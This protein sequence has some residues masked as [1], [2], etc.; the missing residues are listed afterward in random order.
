MK[1]QLP[2][3][4]IRRFWTMLAFVLL[5]MAA[6]VITFDQG[7]SA[8]AQAQSNCGG[9]NQRPCSVFER[10]PS[11]NSGLIEDF[12]RNRC[13]R[14]TPVPTST[15][16][17]RP[18]C[19]ANG[20]R[21]CL[22]TE[23]V[24]SCNSGLVE[25]FSR[26]RC[27]RPTPVPTSTPTP[28]PVCGAN[29]QR[30]CLITERVP[31]C[32]SGLVEDFSRN[33]CVR[34]AP[35]PVLDC[36]AEGQRP[37]LLTERMNS[38]D[39]GLFEDFAYGKCVAEPT[40]GP[41]VQADVDAFMSENRAILEAVDDF[42]ETIT[43]EKN[44]AFFSSGEF[45]RLIEA[46]RFAEIQKRLGTNAFIE[47][48][49][50][51]QIAQGR[52]PAQNQLVGFR[53]SR[54]NSGALPFIRTV[55]IGFTIDAAV[56]AGADYEMGIA[57]DTVNG[58]PDGYDSYSSKYGFSAGASASLQLGL[59]F[60]P[61]E[62]LS[63]GSNGFTVAGGYKVGAALALWFPSGHEKDLYSTV[64]PENDLGFAWSYGFSIEVGVGVEFDVSYLWTYTLMDSAKGQ[65][66]EFGKRA[67]SVFEISGLDWSPCEESL[68][69]K[70][71]KCFPEETVPSDVA[72]PTPNP[73]LA[74]LAGESYKT[75]PDF[76]GVYERVSGGNNQST[77]S[78]TIG[79]DV[80]EHGN[81]NL[82][83][84]GNTIWRLIRRNGSF[85]LLYWDSETQSLGGRQ[86]NL[87]LKLSRY[88]RYAE[89][90]F[91]AMY[92]RYLTGFDL[93][94]ESYQLVAKPVIPWGNNW[95]YLDKSNVAVRNWPWQ[96]PINYTHLERGPAPL[97]YGNRVST[98][99]DYGDDDQN[100]NITTYFGQS[101]HVPLV[102]R[103]DD[104]TLSMQR[105]DGAVVYL[106]GTEIWRTNMPSGAIKSDTYATATVGGADETK[107][108]SIQV[109]A[110]MLKHGRNI[111]AVELHQASANSSDLSFDLYLQANYK[112]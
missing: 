45:S 53:P 55:T 22:I 51:L 67:C 99:L 21:P 87:R 48:L 31:S 49:N 61:P 104:L 89:G 106:N 6:F 56:V 28:R 97:G 94:S 43:S 37:C 46:E 35:K 93:S 33:R 20:Q 14:P 86:G 57:I 80:D 74:R 83:S 79:L 70:W 5:G 10:I 16:T 34:P 11:C 12:S 19:G 96:N 84:N 52:K 59:W 78:I 65:C 75:V 69:E 98:I 107:Q 95:Y 88:E 112:P 77:E 109:D 24:P 101:F 68:T 82:D 3:S 71:G 30:P 39:S 66:G 15:P 17:P 64:V 105:D 111:L 41:N 25:D 102:D 58:T 50:A 63:G 8:P 110:A 54:A 60:I 72:I 42:L 40:L 91:N 90:F 47:K 100:K 85:T 92:R 4:Q 27:V 7:L 38:C 103:L 36:G 2:T 13:V 81:Q 32:N 26:N 1:S 23:R 18:V 108:F 29:G 62:E 44:M 9:N 73:V 76:V